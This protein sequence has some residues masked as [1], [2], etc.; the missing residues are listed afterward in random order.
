MVNA[1]DLPD[2]IVQPLVQFGRAL[3]SHARGQRDGSFAAGARA[4][5]HGE[6]R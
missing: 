6:N 3:M 1:D 2:E 5:V 4:R